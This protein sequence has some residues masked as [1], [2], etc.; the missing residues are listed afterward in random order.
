MTKIAFTIADLQVTWAA[1]L[2]GVAVVQ[3]LVFV[4]MAMFS[5]EPRPEHELRDADRN[6]IYSTVFFAALWLIGFDAKSIAFGSPA[7]A[8]TA[9]TTPGARRASCATLSIGM[10]DK[11][12]L[13]KVGA[14]DEVRKEDET[15]GPGAVMWIYKDSRCAVHIYEGKV[16]F[17]D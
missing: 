5:R 17:I 2:A 3:L 4:T 6:L 8:A 14:A 16:E 11:E 15:R 9:S 12:V 7:S 13:A 1:L 10:T